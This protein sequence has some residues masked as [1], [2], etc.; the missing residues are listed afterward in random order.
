[1]DA[2]NSP[3]LRSPLIGA[4]I[5]LALAAPACLD[6][7][8]ATVEISTNGDCSAIVGTG[9]TAGTDAAVVETDPYETITSQCN[10][11]EIGSIVLY[12]EGAKN[13][14]L[15]FKVV[16]SLG[17]T[18]VE[19]CVAPF[20]GPDCIVARRSMHFV[21]QR[22]F[23]VPISMDLACSGV[24]C[25][26]GQTCVEGTCVKSAIDCDGSEGCDVP[27]EIIPPWRTQIGGPGQQMARHLARGAD[28]VV[29]V[30]GN[31]TESID[32]GAGAI[33]AKGDNDVFVASYSPAGELLWATSF[34]GP[35]LDEGAAVAISPA[36]EIYLLVNF[37]GAVD[38]GGGAVTSKGNS[39]IAL[40]KLTPTGDLL[41][42]VA[43]GSVG[44]DAGGEVA[45]DAGGNV[46]V[47]GGLSDPAEIAGTKVDA[48]GTDAFVASF[49]RDGTLRWAKGI[50]GAGYDSANGVAIDAAGRVYVGGTF[51]NTVQ[52]ANLP[53]VSNGG[54]DAFLASFDA[55]GGLLWA[56]GFG[57]DAQDLVL[58]V[59]ARGE[60]VVATGVLSHPVELDGLLI[61]ATEQDGFVLALETSGTPLW[62]RTFGGPENDQGTE[63]DIGYD[64]SVVLG[65][66]VRKSSAF[67]GPATSG[68]GLRNPFLAVLEA[69]G[70]PRWIRQFETTDLANAEGV[71]ASPDGY[72]YFAGWFNP[73]LDLGDLASEPLTA[74][75]E[76]L[77]L[78]RLAPP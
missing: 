46:Y 33:A 42:A 24:L 2:R 14:P 12:P 58:D 21:P 4:A 25:P 27:P 63:V 49:T 35:G 44:L 77:F 50:G 34:G 28:G 68:M 39:D 52:L 72:A 16:T 10:G 74:D 48:E 56:K 6:P 38:F 31:F 69:D 55:D 11:G 15:V 78:M 7:T 70:E 57:G 51:E 71:A 47:V 36:A 59:A 30:T 61:E 54:G 17:N 23:V 5:Y 8:Q 60:R 19:D 37:E 13:G 1:M 32:F 3:P 76:D 22:S 64:S 73:D 41:W 75:G 62:A 65:G 53:L 67:G 29:T 45:V 18:P 66:S 20:Y 9:I 43:F 26:D 40:L